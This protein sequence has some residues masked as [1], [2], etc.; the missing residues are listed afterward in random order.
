MNDPL[1]SISDALQWAAGELRH[2]GI[3]SPRL[4]AEVLLAHCMNTDRVTL[5]RDAAGTL[6]R[7]CRERFHQAISRRAGHEPVAYITGNK[8]FR[9]LPFRISPDVLIPRPE[10]ETIVD[11]VITVYDE[12][13]SEHD[14]PRIA[15]VGTGSGVI[16]VSLAKEID[17]I[18]VMASDCTARIVELARTNARLNRIDDK[19]CF[20]V[21]DKLTSFVSHDQSERFDCILSNPP[22][23]ADQEWNEAQPEIREYEPEAALRAGPDGLSFYRDIIPDAGRLLR[24]GGYL[25]FEVGRGQ[26]ASVAKLIGQSA[27]FE[28]VSKEVDLSGIARVVKAKKR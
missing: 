18:R 9:S 20:L 12:L 17:G 16:A 3:E 28:P 6:E 22:Y 4:D 2:T 21:A 11:A 13:R 7:D 8:E 15:D 19:I 1:S 23:L 5:Y 25:L 26:D 24:K 14:C 10:T 27:L